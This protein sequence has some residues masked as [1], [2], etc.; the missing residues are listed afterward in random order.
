[1]SADFDFESIDKME[2]ELKI[3]ES[4]KS[5]KKGR[6]S[7]KDKTTKQDK[8][9]KKEKTQKSEKKEEQKFDVKQLIRYLN[10][11][12]GTHLVFRDANDVKKNK[13][14]I[15]LDHKPVIKLSEIESVKIFEQ[16]VNDFMKSKYVK[17]NFD[18]MKTSEKWNTITHSIYDFKLRGIMTTF[19]DCEILEKDNEDSLLISHI[20]PQLHYDKNEEFNKDIVKQ[21]ILE[22]LQ[23]DIID[24]KIYNSIFPH[25]DIKQEEGSEKKTYLSKFYVQNKSKYH[26]DYLI[27]LFNKDN[28]SLFDIACEKIASEAKND[29][30]SKDFLLKYDYDLIKTNKISKEDKEFIE[31]LKKAK[32]EKIISEKYIK[33]YTMCKEQGLLDNDNNKKLLKSYID[34]RKQFKELRETISSMKNRTIEDFIEMFIYAFKEI[35]PIMKYKENIG[36][37]IRDIKSQKILVFTTKFRKYINLLLKGENVKITYK[38]NTFV[39]DYKIKEKILEGEVIQV[40]QFAFDKT[41]NNLAKIGLYVESNPLLKIPKSIRTGL[42]ISIVDYIHNEAL[43]YIPKKRTESKKIQRKIIYLTL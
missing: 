33:H 38:Q 34:T 29:K 16:T 19:N 27:Q 2:E 30:I 31:I 18:N 7:K 22:Y 14:P 12:Y 32:S 28:T 10:T 41:Y 39:T 5:E 15:D 25:P 21:N 36:M 17:D 42:G 13:K 8:K 37:F 4:T 3:E 43:R 23:S 9:D 24:F 35:A 1:M 40:K 6:Q 26:N 20:L 11:C